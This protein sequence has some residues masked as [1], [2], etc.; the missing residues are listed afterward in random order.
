VLILA[1]TLTAGLLLGW[2]VDLSGLFGP[3]QALRLRSARIS[4]TMSRW[5]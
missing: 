1:F 4:W 2:R 3:S 5:R